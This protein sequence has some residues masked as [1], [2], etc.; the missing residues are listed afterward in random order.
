MRKISETDLVRKFGVFLIR[1]ESEID[2]KE[3]WDV[4]KFQAWNSGRLVL[5]R[6][7]AE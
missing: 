4:E 2:I 3:G 7:L 6:A 1:R 5:R